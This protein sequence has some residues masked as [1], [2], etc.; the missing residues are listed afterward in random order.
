MNAVAPSVV[1]PRRRSTTTGSSAPA[2][3][4]RRA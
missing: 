4:G 3:S 2:G 1:R